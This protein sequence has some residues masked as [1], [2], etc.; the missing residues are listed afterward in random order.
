MKLY[1]LILAAVVTAGAA[2][3]QD[4]DCADP[5]LP[6]Q[7]MNF[8]AHQDYL[9]ADLVLNSVYPEVRAALEAMQPDVPRPDGKTEAEALRDA[10]RAWITYRDMACNVE[11]APFRGGT[12][13]PFLTSSCLARLTRDRTEDLLILLPDS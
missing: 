1:V 3:A 2:S 9:D 7:G 13:E 10:Q 6:Q 12:M 8:C 11:A 5:A 4:W